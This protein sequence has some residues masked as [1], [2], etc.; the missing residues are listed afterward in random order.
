MKVSQD[1]VFAFV[2]SEADKHGVSTAVVNK[3]IKDKN[4]YDDIVAHIRNQKVMKLLVEN[5]VIQGKQE[6]TA[7][8][9]IPSNPFE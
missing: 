4:M 9:E 8:V 5:A 6:E 1:D 2:K 3:E 7:D